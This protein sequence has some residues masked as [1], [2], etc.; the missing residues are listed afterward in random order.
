MPKIS[1]V[2]QVLI[3][4]DDLDSSIAFYRDVLGFDFVARFDPPGLGFFQLGDVRLLIER[5]SE[6]ATIYYW[7]NDIDAVAADLIRHGVEFEQ[8]PHLIHVDD[9]GL[10]GRPGEEEWMGFFKDPAGNTVAIATRRTNSSKG[11]AS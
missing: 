3:G 8:P 1:H 4:C 7:V 2:H 6:R 10:F 5:G 11:E 9:Q